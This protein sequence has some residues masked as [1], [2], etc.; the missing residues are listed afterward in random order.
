MFLDFK[1][2]KIKHTQIRKLKSEGVSLTETFQSWNFLR[3][4]IKF[5]FLQEYLFTIRTPS[6]VDK[7][8]WSY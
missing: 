5:T 4:Q 3:Q 8:S 1:Y 7:A 6:S 2:F